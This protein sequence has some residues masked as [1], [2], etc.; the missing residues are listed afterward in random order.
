VIQKRKLIEV[1]LPLEA[2]NIASAAEKSPFTKRHPR[3]LHVWWARRPLAACRAVLFASL[4]DDPSSDP[5][6][7]PTERSQ[8]DERR[9][10]FGII[11]ELVRWSSTTN[12][13]VLERA[14]VEI[15]RSTDGKVPVVF[16]P[17][18]GGGSIPIEAQR[19]G[20]Q[21]QATDLNPVA[22]LITKALVEIPPKFANLPPVHPEGRR[23]VG[24]SGTWLGAT[25][26]GDD[27]RRYGAWIRSEARRRIGAL[28]PAARMPDGG[29]ARL[30]ASIWAR[31]VSCPNPSCG[32]RMPLVRSFALSTKTGKEAW[33]QPSVDR[34]ARTVS[35]EIRAGSGTPREGTV[36]RNGAVCLICSTPVALEFIR[37][38]GRAGRIGQQLM[39]TVAE[40]DGKR[41]YLSPTDEQEAAALAADPI[42]MPDTDLPERALGFRVQAY[43]MTKHRD[44]F[45]RRQLATFATFTV[46]VE[47]CRSEVRRDALLA[48][49]P[50][51]GIGLAAGGVGADA[52]ADALATYLGLAVSRLTDFGN[53]LASWDSGNANM[54]QLF[55]RQV[56]P[57]A[58]DFAETNLIDG[59]VSIDSGVQ[60]VA[61]T[62]EAVPATATATVVQADAASM[63]VAPEMLVSTDPPYYDNIG[64]ADLSD[65]FYVWLRQ[66]LHEVWPQLFATVLTPKSNELVAD[67]GR[68]GGRDK[69][70]R[71]FDTGMERTFASIRQ[72]KPNGPI[73]IFY[74]FKQTESD[75]DA[76]GGFAVAS[77]GWETMLEALMRAQLTIVGTWPMRTEQQQRSRALASNAL[78]SSIVL[79]CR[80]RP[81]DAGITTRK[82]FVAALKSEL[83]EALRTLQH[84]NIAPVDL[85]Q[86][87]IGPGMAVFSRYARVLEPDG[88]AMPV[89]TALALIN[90][91][92]DEL[93]TEQEGEFDADT[94]WA[95]A[96]YEQFGLKDADFGTAEIL[97]KAKNTS[98][99]GLVAA[100][101]L[102]APKGRVRLLARD[103]YDDDWNPVTDRR[104]PVWEVMQ[105]LI[106]ALL[107]DGEAGAAELL[108]PLGGIG[109]TSRDLSYRLYHVAERKGWTEE[110][111][112]YNALVVAW[113]DLIRGAEQARSRQPAQASLG[114]ER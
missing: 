54:R 96:W 23:G 105:R 77:T 2:I 60:W 15:R 81:T 89:R 57:M 71:F 114:L 39:A 48:G 1:A 62:L 92:L 8:D 18:C 31:T 85:A 29:E 64:Y 75:E 55:A 12:E 33:V 35:F 109:D 101:I 7:F 113:P 4:V 61:T 42:W 108:A 19:L 17:F 107:V 46:L 93:L 41:R 91:A 103:E 80:P 88:S 98:V 26:L 90:Q 76:D 63:T 82:D 36:G 73:T 25:G 20:L 67:A 45:T 16:D 43:G 112:A 87:S 68:L 3:A 34:A 56:I 32:G 66:S 44:L 22:V 106:R 9:R 100:G 10:L 99:S 50:D 30:V 37:A 97:S 28:Y 53:A 65:F 49:L 79:V 14:R 84:G 13:E 78:A 70:R 83:P 40:L 95:I 5:D 74:A 47:E 104:L 52:Y 86:A 51:D 6:H 69:A 72:A 27:V 111:R 59:V 102:A 38:E 21:V 24:A 94:R 58:W 110:A 11:E